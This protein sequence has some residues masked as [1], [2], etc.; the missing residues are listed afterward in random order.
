[1]HVVRAKHRLKFLLALNYSSRE[2]YMAEFKNGKI[3]WFDEKKGY[4]FIIDDNDEVV[5]LHFS[6]VPK[7]RIKDLKAGTP[8]KFKSELDGE[9]LR[10]K[11]LDIN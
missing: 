9:T 8:V 1:M 11:D 10:A 5:F 2:E 6:S 7:N 3:K 4:G